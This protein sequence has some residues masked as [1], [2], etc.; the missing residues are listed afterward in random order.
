[1]KG[2]TVM[3]GEPIPPGVLDICFAEVARCDCI[4]V[5]GTSAT[6]YPA[7]SFP[8]LVRESG[9]S[10]IE[11]NPNETPLTD[12]AD[13]VL[14]GPTGEALPLIVERVKQLKS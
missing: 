12:L 11:A 5:A 8:G 2:D 7:A 13:L 4:V 10:V 3:F 9:G 6:V 14:R 1:M